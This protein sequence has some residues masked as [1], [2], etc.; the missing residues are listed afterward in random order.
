[1]SH[2]MTD[3]NTD[4]AIIH[5][6]VSFGIEER[7]LEN[8]GREAYFVGCRI[9]ISIDCLRRHQPACAVNGLAIIAVVIVDV[10]HDCVLDIFPIR[11]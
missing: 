9:I 2:L 6:I 8:T 1:M 11:L 4:S 3:Y 7:R 10:E 5:S